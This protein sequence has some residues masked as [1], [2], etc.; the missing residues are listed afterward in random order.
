[1][2]TYQKINDY[3]ADK[4]HAVHDFSSDTLSIALSNTAPASETNDPSA[5]G[6][7]VLANV[8]EISY[9]NVSEALTITIDSEGQSGGT[10][11]I[12]VAD[13]TLTASGGDFGPFQYVYVYNSGTAEATNPLI[14]YADNGSSITIT[15]GNEF[16]VDFDDANGLFQSA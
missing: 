9:T 6:N 2:A 12:T 14:A 11:Q 8:T 16:K 4:H 5:D 10:Y 7:G 3:E 1:M 15:D 13:K